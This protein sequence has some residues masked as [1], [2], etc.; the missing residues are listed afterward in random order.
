MKT[1]A[2]KLKRLN[3][4]FSPLTIILLIFLTAYCLSV[5]YSLYWTII[6]SFKVNKYVFDYDIFGFPRY[7]WYKNLPSIFVTEDGTPVLKA[8]IAAQ[9]VKNAESEGGALFYTYRNI[10]KI[11]SIKVSATPTSDA[12]EVFMPQMYLNSFMYSFGCAVTSTVV[13]C[14]T[15]YLCARFKFRFS[16]FVRNIVI[17]VMIIPIIGSMPSEISMAAKLGILDA[18]YGLWIMKANFLG[19]YFLV[20]YEIFKSLPAGYFEAAKI[21]GAGNLQILCKIAIPLVKNTILTVFLI[22][23]VE[24]WNDYQ[25]PL[26]FMSSYPTVARGLNNLIEGSWNVAGVAFNPTHV[27]AKM[28]AVVLTAVPV[29]VIFLAFQN[30]LL[31]NLTMG[32]LK[33]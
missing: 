21:D 28:A 24:F 29:V 5:L 19:M 27:P 26:V 31:G 18:P 6:T 13:P 20:F 30:R 16:E 12:K 3:K 22:R 7:E 9:S 33:G 1:T 2:K 15:A 10:I 23:F 4:K 11:F 14:V 25:T 17:V 8:L 32:G